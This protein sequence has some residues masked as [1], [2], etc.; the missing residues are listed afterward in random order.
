MK[1]K[2]I[3]YLK[4]IERIQEESKNYVSSLS[5]VRKKCWAFTE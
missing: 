4:V 1:E 2:G 5:G 3:G